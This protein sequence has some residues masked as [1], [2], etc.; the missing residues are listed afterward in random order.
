MFQD[1][2]QDD[3]GYDPGQYLLHVELFEP[4][5]EHIT[6]AEFDTESFRQG[7]DLPRNAKPKAEGGKNVRQELWQVDLLNKHALVR[8]ER[9][10]HVDQGFIHGLGAFE[11]IY[12]HKRCDHRD[13]GDQAANLAKTEPQHGEKDHKDRRHGEHQRHNR[14]E[15]VLESPAQPHRQANSYSREHGCGEGDKS[16][17][18]R[19]R[20][21]EIGRFSFRPH[22]QQIRPDGRRDKPGVGQHLDVIHQ[23]CGHPPDQDQD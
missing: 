2:H 17:A 19:D 6:D 11:H 18:Q 15:R 22:R 23:N 14:H 21:M 5:E 13:D 8:L 1:E 4:K 16:S 12:R 20:H 10:R 9:L 3:K 7:Y